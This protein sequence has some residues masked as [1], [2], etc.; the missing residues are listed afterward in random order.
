[1][2]IEK[3]VALAQH[4]DIEY[5]LWNEQYLTGISQE[6]ID[7]KEEEL[8]SDEKLSGEE[9][10][11]ILQNWI[12][13]EYT[14]LED[15]FKISKYDENR[16]EYGN[17]E[18]LVLT[19]DEADELSREQTEQLIEDCYLY[20]YKKDE[21]KSGKSN[22]LLQFLDLEAW[23]DDWSSNRGEILASYDSEENDITIDNTTY[24]IYR[25]N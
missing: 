1:M 21:E 2:E 11:E 15:E 14:L 10:T 24:Y 17:Q 3:I 6:E 12:D 25:T 13:E 8:R 22:P 5:C 4:L 16:I 20:E 9:I 19:D 7:E 23:I 18:Y